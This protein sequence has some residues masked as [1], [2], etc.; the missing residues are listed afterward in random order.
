MKNVNWGNVFWAVVMWSALV[1][2]ILAMSLFFVSLLAQWFG[3]GAIF[4][5]VG[6]AVVAFAADFTTNVVVKLLNL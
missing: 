3:T 5:I 2:G 6:F 1:I 4:I